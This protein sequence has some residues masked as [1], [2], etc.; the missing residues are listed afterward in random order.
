MTSNAVI[1]TREVDGGI[2]NGDGS[3]NRDPIHSAMM[4]SR[5]GFSETARVTARLRRR[6][7][8]VRSPKQRGLD[9]SDSRWGGPSGPTSRVSLLPGGAAWPGWRS[10]YAQ[11]YCVGDGWLAKISN[12]WIYLHS[13]QVILCT[14]P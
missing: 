14:S 12:D 5:A 2:G 8:L 3:T 1:R 13:V 9:L 10:L 6:A 7:D 11:R 4:E